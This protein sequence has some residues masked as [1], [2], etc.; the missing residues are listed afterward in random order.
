MKT[1]MSAVKVSKMHSHVMILLQE[2]KH[3]LGLEFL[4]CEI[5]QQG[6]QS[7]ANMLQVCFH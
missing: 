4:F 1:L 2:Y 6:I 5:N 3:Y 7:L